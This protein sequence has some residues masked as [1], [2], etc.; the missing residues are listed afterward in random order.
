MNHLLAIEWL[1]IKRYRTFWVLIG[2]FAFLFPIWNFAINNGLF[3][4]GPIDVLGGNYSFSDVWRNVTAHASFF[5]IFIA[6]LTA[7]LVTNEY[8]YKTH[9]QN[10][11]DGWSRM[12]VYHAKWLVVIIL[13]L[14]ITI[15]VMLTGILL[16]V[17]KGASWGGFSD[18]IIRLVW[19]FLLSLNYL[20]FG[21]LL[22]HLV[23]RSGLAISLL[24][25]YSLMLENLIHF[26]F[27]FGK[28]IAWVDVLLPLQSS[29]QLT[30]LKFLDVDAVTTM[31]IKMLSP[32]TYA[33]ASLCWIT[34]YYI[35]GRAR[36]LRSDW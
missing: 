36:L 19:I 34:L 10:M 17:V 14:A 4:I 18:S 5:I 35:I 31:G 30:P 11:I 6:I 32:T 21:M 25:I 27:F 3:R 26:Y 12:Q 33:I 22:G 16:A 9:R 24:V 29:D 20:G 7:I 8:N 2:L 23:K 1:K 28:K 13:S 15:F